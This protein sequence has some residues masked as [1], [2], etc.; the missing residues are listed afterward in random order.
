M[1]YFSRI[2]YIVQTKINGVENL[3][4]RLEG[5]NNGELYRQQAAEKIN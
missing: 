3:G 2:V 1:S 4:K 5:V